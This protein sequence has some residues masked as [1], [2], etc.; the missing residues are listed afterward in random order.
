M[1]IVVMGGSGLIGKKLV[2]TLCALGHEA[3]AASPSSGINAVTGEGLADVLVDAQVVV[4]VMNSPSFE[5]AAVLEFFEKSSQNL[6]AA[7][8]EAGVSHHVALSVVGADRIPDSGYLRAKVAQ[9]RLIKSSGI[10]YTILRAT[11]FFEFVGAITQ[12]FADGKTVRV[13]SAFIQPVMS[14]DVVSVLVD[15]TLGTPINGIVEL[16]GPEQ[17]CFD[18]L[19]RRF[20]SA[21]QDVRQVV[22]DSHARYFGAELDNN[23]LIPEDDSRF[24]STRFEDWLSHL[25]IPSQNISGSPRRHASRF[26]GH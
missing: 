24:G 16:A 26:T 22:A 5:D 9:E 23:S 19:V 12:S 10:N 25:T 15:I 18:E 6:L 4:D 7:E 2:S 21:N 11:Q 14:D 20:L 3:V 8:V 1:K 13:P 17:Y